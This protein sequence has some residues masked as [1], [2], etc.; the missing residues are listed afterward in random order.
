LATEG[1]AVMQ[2]FA[3]CASAVGVLLL[4]GFLV[5]AREL[6]SESIFGAPRE[7]D[8]ERGRVYMNEDHDG[9]ESGRVNPGAARRRHERTA[10]QP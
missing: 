4:I 3:F 6:F 5:V 9:V 10:L 2:L 8:E 1:L 7:P